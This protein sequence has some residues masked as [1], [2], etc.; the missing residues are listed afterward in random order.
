M[1]GLIA[2]TLLLSL[3]EPA[4]GG[5]VPYRVGPGDLLEV[6]VEGRP[7]LSRLPTVQTTGAIWLPQAGE[8]SVSGLSVEEIAARIAPL[9]AEADLEKPRVTI[10]VREYH[11]QSVWTRGALARPGRK[12]LRGGTRLVDVL[13][14][15]GG[16]LPTATGEVV[17]E[18]TAGAFED[19]SRTLNLRFS[20]GN[21]NDED[22]QGMSLPLAPGDVV[23]AAARAWVVL[24]G[25]VRRP[26]RFFYDGTLTLSRAVEGAGGLLPGANRRVRVRRG[27]RATGPRDVEADLDAIR[28]GKQEDVVLVPGDEIV[29]EARLL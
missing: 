6:V 12:Q 19:G 25:A 24:S 10:R 13:L 21:P 11:S 14:D 9:L 15:S 20:R 23:T 16:F 29:V 3:A 5:A 28:R 2:A 22:L 8:V 18:R 27:E 1:S 26:G 17:I 7:D 4:Q